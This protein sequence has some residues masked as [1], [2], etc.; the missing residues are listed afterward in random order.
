VTAD[1]VSIVVCSYNNWPDLDVA[2][3]SALCQSYAKVE[4]IVVDNSS[5]DS[6]ATSVARE[7]GNR[8]R[9]Y[10]QP[11]R[12]CAGA[13]NTGFSLARGD[14]VQFL[15]GDDVLVPNKIEKQLELFRS[16]P[17]LDI[18]YD[19]IRLFQSCGGTVDWLDVST[20]DEVDMMRG[21]LVPENY[22]AGINVLGALFRRRT[23]EKVGPWDES[24]YCEDTDYWLRAAWAGCQFGRSLLSPAGFK[25]VRSGQKTANAS[26]LDEGFEAVL[27]KALGYVTEPQY[28]RLL[29][30]KLAQR[31]FYVGISRGQKTRTKSLV[32]LVEARAASPSAVSMRA[33]V[34]GSAAIILPGGDWLARSQRLRSIRRLVASLA[35]YRTPCR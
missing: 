2:I 26:L 34:A 16:K 21:L 17:T 15:D 33:L 13:Y 23:V 1:L 20:R 11:N 12:D 30:D 6:T 25:R 5:C 3:A 22:G 14:F 7:F 10:Q 31:R 32:K 19:D 8:I 24:L 27:V 9:F 29:A 18:V 28:R 35:R 4:V